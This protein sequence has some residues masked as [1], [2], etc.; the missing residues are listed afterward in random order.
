MFYSGNNTQG[1]N[2][3]WEL[4]NLVLTEFCAK[5]TCKVEMFFPG[6]INRSAKTTFCYGS[7][8]NNP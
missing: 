3:T 5:E 6:N 4:I 2:F 7:V 1:F 8:C